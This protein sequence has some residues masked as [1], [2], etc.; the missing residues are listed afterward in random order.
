MARPFFGRRGRWNTLRARLPLAASNM[1]HQLLASRAT[2]PSAGP[3]FWY[4]QTPPAGALR[5]A[6]NI[7]CM[8][9]G[10]QMLANRETKGAHARHH[11]T[12]P[13]LSANGVCLSAR[14]LVGRW[15]CHRDPY[16]TAKE[17]TG[18]VFPLRSGGSYIRHAA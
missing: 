14:A 11:T 3:R 8:G 5:T 6:G 13:C 18:N 2:P 9:S 12:Q 7:T 17:F 1:G 4:K 15:H 16:Q 10:Q